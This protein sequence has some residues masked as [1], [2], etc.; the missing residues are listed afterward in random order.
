VPQ[1]FTVLCILHCA[2][3]CE[4]N[5]DDDDDDDYSGFALK[6]TFSAGKNFWRRRCIKT[7]NYLPISF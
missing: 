7:C 4:L 6:I 1:H 5:D 2:L 3:L